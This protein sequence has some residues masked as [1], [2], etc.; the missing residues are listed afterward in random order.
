[1]KDIWRI[2][3]FTKSLWRQYAL[4]SLFTILLAA[5][6]QLVPLFTKGAI[7][8]ISKVGH[9]AHPD[10]TRVA[11][12]AILIFL[13]DFGQTL[14][15]NVGGY[16]GDIMSVKLQ[17]LLSQRYY[18]HVLSLPQKYF[19]TELSG[20]IINRMSRGIG[21]ITQFM[22]MMSNNFLQ[23]LFSTI[24]SLAIVAYYS[25]QVALMLGALYPVFIWLTKR[26]S[27][28][29]QSYQKVINE[30]QDIASGRFAESIGQVR[31]VK[32]FLQ[33]ARE[34]KF[35]GKRYDKVVETTHPQSKLWHTQDV[36]RRSVLNIIFLGVFVYIFV[37][38]ARGAYSIGTMVLLIQFA[39]LIR[40]PIFTI[41][42]L[43][44]QTQRA[45][46]NTRDYFEAMDVQPE[47]AD[48][49]NAKELKVSRGEIVFDDVH[50]SYSEDKPVLKGVSFT[51]KADSKVALVGESGEGKTTLTNLLLR[52]YD[53][54]D[55]QIRID[56]Q[57]VHDVTQASLRG[58]IGVVF[59]EP[60]LFSGTIRENIAYGRPG[61][62]V[63]DVEAAARAANADEFIRK[64]DKQYETEIGER[65][66]KLS[67]GQKQRIAIA[68]ALLK[69]A[70]I[71]I[72]DEATS[73][74]DSRSESMV[75]EALERLMHGRTTIIIAHRLSTIRN[76][77]QIITL[78]GG[79]V[80]ET[81]SP[82][83]LAR[84]TGIYAELLK[85]QNRHNESGDKE[86]KK[87]EIAG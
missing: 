78:G 66:L 52:L 43:V 29:W 12:F 5:M 15:S 51:V 84:G 46:S 31:V 53:V 4:I 16:I 73:S 65:G 50:F 24:F 64:F 22:Q 38:T 19:D 18:Q 1:M 70:P 45:V 69:N 49:E 68:R 33:E 8:E 26:S 14:L 85:L 41:S 37:E 75:Q 86:L 48:N 83:E 61:A 32:S 74:L 11:I 3:T 23:F 58:A 40:I 10:V 47:I 28:K 6:S 71:L 27:S 42:F 44:D 17:Q 36:L 77:D 80:E 79:K 21:Q 30:E 2:L 63:K 34:L 76:V 35:F 87:Y 57:V 56:G 55:G 81:G 7:D 59:Q 67:G 20:K 39:M 60:A 25:W 62:S 13:T 72:L 82:A 54:T 9:N